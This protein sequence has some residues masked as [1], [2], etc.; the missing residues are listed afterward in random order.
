MCSKIDSGM[1]PGQSIRNS[2]ESEN[3]GSND[4]NN[5]CQEETPQVLSDGYKNF[6][7]EPERKRSL[8]KEHVSEVNHNTEILFIAMA[9]VHLYL[10]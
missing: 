2:F 4:K 9:Y 7:Y 3:S 5:S 10:S 1:S 6:I 8:Q